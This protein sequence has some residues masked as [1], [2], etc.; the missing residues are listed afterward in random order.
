MKTFQ[1]GSKQLQRIQYID[2]LVQDWG[3]GA[4]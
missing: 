1:D 3:K 4:V 2:G